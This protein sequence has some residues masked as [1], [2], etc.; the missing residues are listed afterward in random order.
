MSANPDE[1][2]IYRVQ[3]CQHCRCDLE[4]TAPVAHE[5]RQVFDLPPVRVRVT[6]HQAEVKACPQCGEQTK[7]AFPSGVSQPVQYGPRLKAQM[8]YFNHYHFVSL[9]RVA[10][11]MVDWYGQEVSEGTIVSAGL[12]MPSRSARSMSRSKRNIDKKRSTLSVGGFF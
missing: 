1:V 10:E 7:A 2:Q 8:V 12:A 11:I 9:E 5:R 4:N 3:R 6:E